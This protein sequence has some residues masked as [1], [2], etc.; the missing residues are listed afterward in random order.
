MPQG[1]YVKQNK[2]EEKY[3][4]RLL[5]RHVDVYHGEERGEKVMMKSRIP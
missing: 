3:Q 4:L 2:E 5:S 1:S